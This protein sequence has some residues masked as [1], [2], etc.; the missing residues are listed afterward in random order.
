MGTTQKWVLLN[1]DGV[2][3]SPED[4]QKLV[5]ALNED[6]GECGPFAAA[7]GRSASTRV[8]ANPDDRQA[9]EYAM[10]I[11]HSIPEAPE[12]LA[13]HKVTNGVP[14]IE[15]GWDLFD[16]VLDGPDPF[17]VG[18]DH[19]QKEALRDPGANGWK[20]G[21]NSNGKSSADE[22]CD[23]VQNTFRSASNGVKGVS[24]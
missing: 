15:I 2:P 17:S 14:D 7:T 16:G 20:D 13:Y 4:A 11:R 5:D 1:I 9:D 22:A 23:K 18:V 24:S 8:G 21:V 3:L 10:N 19:E 12:A 6:N